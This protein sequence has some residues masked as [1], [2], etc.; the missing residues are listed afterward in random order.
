[1][2]H[3]ITVE[4]LKSLPLPIKDSQWDAIDPNFLEEVV[5][6]AGTFVENYLDNCVHLRQRSERIRGSNRSALILNF[7]P[8]VSLDYIAAH[9]NSDSAEVRSTSE[10]ILHREAGMI[11][12]K[13]RYRN[14]FWDKNDYVVRYTS[15]WVSYDEDGNYEEQIPFPI[16]YATALQ[17]YEML[18]PV[19]RGS[20][21]MTPVDLVPQTSEKFVELLEF[22]KRKRIA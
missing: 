6:S 10:F 7:Y 16:K 19:L 17:A 21:D 3:I 2:S 12:W 22:Y 15:G 13:D 4:Y 9:D 20:R 1:V 11:E 14:I 8:L 18:Q 5:E